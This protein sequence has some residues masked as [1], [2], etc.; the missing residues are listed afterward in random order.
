MSAA[1]PTSE[2]T[3][4]RVTVYA[5][6]ATVDLSLPSRVQISSLAQQVAHVAVR[7]MKELN[8]DTEWLEN[9]SSEILLAP[10][11]GTSWDPTTSLEDNHVKDGDYILLTV[12]DADERYPELIEVMQD[13]TAIERNAR[14]RAWDTD[15]SYGYASYSFPVLISVI[16]LV[17]G[18]AIHNFPQAVPFRWG[19]VAVLAVLGLVCLSMSFASRMWNVR[20]DLVGQSLAV[21]SYLPVMVAAACAVPGEL[22]RWSVLSGSVAGMVVS[23]VFI[24]ANRPPI[25]AHYAVLVPSLSTA[26]GVV[27]GILIGTWREVPT[28][29]I[30]AIIGGIAIIVFHFEPTLSRLGARLELPYLPARTADGTDIAAANIIEVS[31]TLTEDSSWDSMINQRERNIAARYNGLGIIIGVCL[32]ILASGMVAARTTPAGDVQYFMPQLDQ[33]SV[34]LFHFLVICS[35][36]V[37]GGSWY[38]DRAMRAMSMTG[39]ALAWAGYTYMCATNDPE[40]DTSTARVLVALAMFLIVSLIAAAMAWRARPVRSARA[41]KWGERFEHM[42]YL[43]PI[44]NVVML[45]NLVFLIRHR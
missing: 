41:R 31:R 6:D 19:T 39:G 28:G 37:L 25:P 26:L 45:L 20:D 21:A 44:I 24:L 35:I 18:A 11:M 1:A 33:R 43:F 13:A 8:L 34:M 36:F 12:R 16:A 17:A 27:A 38:R 30:A 40:I 42:L 32:T 2:K 4:V 7:R 23:L 15:T 9:P 22:T 29:T 5:G 3:T 14:F 10:T